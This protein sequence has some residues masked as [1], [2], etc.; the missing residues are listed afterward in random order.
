MPTGCDGHVGRLR[1]SPREGEDSCGPSSPSHC[2]AQLSPACRGSV[3]TRGSLRTLLP[4]GE[5][6]S[7]PTDSGQGWEGLFR[8]PRAWPWDSGQLLHL[9]VGQ[10]S[11]EMMKH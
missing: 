7:L 6:L 5:T 3:Y 4:A 8:D 1:G 9:S 2:A 10:D 11:P